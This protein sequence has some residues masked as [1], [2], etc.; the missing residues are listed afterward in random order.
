MLLPGI[1]MFVHQKLGTMYSKEALPDIESRKIF[2]LF[3][4]H[5]QVHPELCRQILADQEIPKTFQRTDVPDNDCG[6]WYEFE[7]HDLIGLY[8]AC[9]SAPSIIACPK[10]AT[11]EE[12]DKAVKNLFEVYRLI[13]RSRPKNSNVVR[14]P[15]SHDLEVVNLTGP[16]RC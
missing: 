5:L 9:M 10:E 2:L 12:K 14:T 16:K 13:K 11:Q 8:Q 4:R 3:I 7:P 1:T 6:I 15:F